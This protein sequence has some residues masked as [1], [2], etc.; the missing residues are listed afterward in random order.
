MTVS[1]GATKVR[2]ADGH[3]RSYASPRWLTELPA[4]LDGEGAVTV[5]RRRSAVPVGGLASGELL[6]G[7]RLVGARDLH[8]APWWVPA[9]AVWSDAEEQQRPEHPWHA[10]LAT[11]R[12]WSRAVLSGLSDRLGWEA[13]QAFEAGE[14][15]AT[16]DGVG[17]VG[18]ATVYDGRIGHDVPTVLITS[19]KVTRWG[20]GVTAA[21]AYRRAL[22]GDQGLSEDDAAR[23]L[24]DMQLVLADAGLDIAVVDIGTSL[25]RRAGVARV[26]VQLMG[27]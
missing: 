20:A 10:G 22:F 15:L 19:E 27:R 12:S 11:D 7:R 21:S 3:V 18:A 26:S 17:Q 16:L 5:L 8:D 1:T 4:L 9:T 6:E 25:L 23:E 2:P 13:R 14:S 24:A